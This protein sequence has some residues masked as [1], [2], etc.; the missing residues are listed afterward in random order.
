[1]ERI[2]LALPTVE[3]DQPTLTFWEISIRDSRGTQLTA[4]KGIEIPWDSN[5]FP[6]DMMPALWSPDMQRIALNLRI[7]SDVD[8]RIDIIMTDGAGQNSVEVLHNSLFVSWSPDNLHYI[9]LI[10]PDGT[11]GDLLV[12]TKE[13]YLCQ[14][15]NAGQS[16]PLL[17]R[18]TANI[19]PRSIHW[20]NENTY[21][22]ETIE[23]G[24]NVSWRGVIGGST[25]RLEK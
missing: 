5:P 9:F 19:D 15:D 20:L 4:Y 13:I 2:R 1:M 3:N 14:A 6:H 16:I 7:K 24:G 25:I 23:S 17:P 21:V 8:D 18:A 10:P 11:N 22:F 12:G